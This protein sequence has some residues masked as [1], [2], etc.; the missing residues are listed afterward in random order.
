[1]LEPGVHSQLQRP[2]RPQADRAPVHHVSQVNSYVGEI[3]ESKSSN[4]SGGRLKSD[5]GEITLED[6]SDANL[7]KFTP[8]SGILYL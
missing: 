8:E 4:F 6:I 7:L 5:S 1:M 3:Y 2:D